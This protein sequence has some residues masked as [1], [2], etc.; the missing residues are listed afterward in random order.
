MKI[1]ALVWS[2]F[3]VVDEKE[4]RKHEIYIP[5]CP[6]HSTLLIHPVT[7]PYSLLNAPPSHC[8]K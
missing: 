1:L 5:E 3:G 7:H 8:L 2:I 6:S 4:K